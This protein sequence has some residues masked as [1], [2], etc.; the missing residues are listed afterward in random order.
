MKRIVFLM[1]F[2]CAAAVACAPD[3]YVIDGKI[4]GLRGQISLVDAFDH[5]IQSSEITDGRFRFE[6]VLDT[7]QLMYVN[8]GLGQEFP[9]DTPVLLENTR[10]KLRGDVK[11]FDISVTGTRANV[12]M[13]EYIRRK[14][15]LPE[16]DMQAYAALVRETFDANSDNLLGAML[17]PNLA[18]SVSSEELLECISKLPEDL[19]KG[20]LIEHFE[21]RAQAVVNTSEGRKFTD[22]EMNGPDGEAVSLASVVS[23]HEATLLVFWASW[24]RQAVKTVGAYAS[25]VKPYEERGAT[26]MCVSLDYDK[27]KWADASRQAGI[28]GTNICDSVQKAQ[29]V[30]ELY[31]IDGMPR[32]ILIGRDGTIL[33]RPASASALE[34]EVALR[35]YFK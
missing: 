14:K 12:N 1:A 9:I 31:G 23:S 35:N 8:N 32:A 5:V 13:T 21:K 30:N 22:F 28:F 16:T 7:P 11:T 27:A 19:R 24:A 18:P 33:C 25:A 20:Q 26:M 6:G 10:I 3:G 17:I 4:E 2:M 29:E 15:Q 34:I